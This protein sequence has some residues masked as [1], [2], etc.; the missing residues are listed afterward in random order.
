MKLSTK[1]LTLMPLT[2]ELLMLMIEKD[3]PQLKLNTGETPHKKSKKEDQ[4]I[5]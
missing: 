5:Y 3:Q 2:S 4:L 1:E